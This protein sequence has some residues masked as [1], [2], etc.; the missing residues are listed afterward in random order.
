M[1]LSS[2]SFPSL[3]SEYYL[4]NLERL[5][6]TVES[7][8][9]DL[10]TIEEMQFLFQW[11]L[12]PRK[13][14]MLYARLIARKGNY[15]RVSKLSYKEIG[16]IEEA[17][18]SLLSCGLLS[19][20]FLG[21]PFELLSLFTKDEILRVGLD[22]GVIPLEIRS[23]R[24]DQIINLLSTEDLVIG[25]LKESH[26]IYTILMKH[27]LDH[28]LLL[29][30]GNCRQDLTSFILSQL[31]IQKHEAY[32]FS[33]ST[34]LF[35]CREDIEMML[36]LKRASDTLAW[37]NS[38]QLDSEIEGLLDLVV[39]FKENKNLSIAKRQG[40]LCNHL[41]KFYE[42][43]GQQEKALKCYQKTSLPPS[44]E[45]QA[46]LLKKHSCV[47]EYDKLLQEMAESSQSPE[48]WYFS[49]DTREKQRW[50]RKL[51]KES[52]VLEYRGSVEEAA[53]HF[54][55]G[56]CFFSE[57]LL[58]QSLLGLS[59]WDIIYSPVEGAFVNAYQLGPLDLN[60]PHFYSK[61]QQEIEN[62]LS[63]I[64]NDPDWSEKVM[65][66]WNK[67]HGLANALVHWNY[68]DTVPFQMVLDSIP[69][70]VFSQ[71]FRRMLSHLRVYRTGFP[72]LIDV[73]NPESD[74]PFELI[75]VKGPGDQLRPNQLA[76]LYFFQNKGIPARILQVI[77]K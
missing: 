18:R 27:L 56:T 11:N 36:K 29:Y 14:K 43:T 37:A 62:R 45:R 40:R 35:N 28:F 41:G 9:R 31:G 3:E 77:K 7:V 68:L 16:N 39:S 17:A 4:E 6:E 54:I 25:K 44:R 73:G 72:D 50:R 8:Y 12:L 24:K 60:D 58:W 2:D 75:E 55:G 26:Q 34:R 22:L 32:I 19:I 49:M 33:E 57:N 38:H 23:S 76:W 15:F 70:L 52:V 65:E 46:R 10:L 59:I 63:F 1:T 30:F 47:K 66:T 71:I 5:F 13:S 21:E 51:D 64:K 42:R 74:H 20:E 69:G 61:R 67:K 53:S 48:E